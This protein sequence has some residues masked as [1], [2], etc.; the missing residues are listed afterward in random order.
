MP[1]RAAN[2]TAWT[3]TYADPAAPEY[4]ERNLRRAVEILSITGLANL[5]YAINANTREIHSAV[6]SDAII[7]TYA[8]APNPGPGTAAWNRA[9]EC[10]FRVL[11]GSAGAEATSP[12][13][14]GSP[15]WGA[16]FQLVRHVIHE[17]SAAA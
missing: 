3:S 6:L 10:A 1:I 2:L 8:G 17:N 5:I 9:M 7:L 13:T 12:G 14:W 15:K 11:G 16:P 4:T